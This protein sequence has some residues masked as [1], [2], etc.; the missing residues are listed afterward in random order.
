MS[1]TTN[2]ALDAMGGDH[3]PDIVLGGVDIGRQRHPDLRF[4]LY[5][6][7]AILSP[8]IAKLGGLREIV[9]IHHTAEFVGGDDKPSQA[10]R[11]RGTSLRLAIEAVK[12]NEAQA[13]VSA[14]NT[15]ALMGLSVLTLGTLSG[16]DRPAIAGF[17]PTINGGEAVILDLGANASCHAQNLVQFAVMG[18]VFARTLLGVNEPT[19]GLLNIG[20]ESGKGNDVVRQAAAIMSDVKLQMRFFGFV[21]GNDILSGKVDV[22]V[23]DGFTG[24]VAVKT[25]EGTARLITT[26]LNEAFHSSILASIGYLFARRAL[27]KMR[28]R[29]DPRRYNGAMLLGLNGVVVKSHGGTDAL[30]FATA[31]DTAYDMIKYGFNSR[32]ADELENLPAPGQTVAADSGGTAVADHARAGPV[33]RDSRAASR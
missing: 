30:G 9:T 3:A 26:F 32:I 6:D 1:A 23:T 31:I 28:I 17:L 10:V 7:E 2:I 22:V 24:N 29:A 12:Q 13:I 27:D 19:I 21:E 15:G 25:V 11:R 4:Q 33:R 14:G 20:S 16:I 8:A 18:E 5:G